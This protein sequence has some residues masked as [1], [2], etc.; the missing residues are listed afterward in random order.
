MQCASLRY[1]NK[2]DAKQVET[3]KI[4]GV[5]KQFVRIF[6]DSDSDKWEFEMR[7]DET[8]EKKKLLDAGDMILSENQMGDKHLG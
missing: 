5:L 7:E 8:V 1:G 2:P 3:G 4:K 6:D